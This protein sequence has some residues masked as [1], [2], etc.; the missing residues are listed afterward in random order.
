VGRETEFA[1]PYELARTPGGAGAAG[2]LDLIPV[3]R[4]AGQQG[5][6]QGGGPDLGIRAEL[7]QD[8]IQR[9]RESGLLLPLSPPRCM[10]SGGACTVVKLQ[11]APVVVPSPFTSSMRQ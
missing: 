10:A 9:P 5:E 7:A 3:H 6:D 1:E 11:V 2:L 4:A 8:A